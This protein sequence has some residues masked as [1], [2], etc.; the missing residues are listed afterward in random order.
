[1]TALLLHDTGRGGKLGWMVEDI[2][3]GRASGAILSAVVTPKPA[4]ISRRP[5]V[6]DALLQLNAIGADVLL[7]PATHLVWE[8]GAEAPEWYEQWDWWDPTYSDLTTDEGRQA[9]IE[10]VFDTQR[11]LGLRPLAPTVRIDGLTGPRKDI[12]L[13]MAQLAI[14]LEPDAI[15][16]LAGDIGFWGQGGRLDEF[17]GE[18]AQLRAGG[19]HVIAYTPSNRYGPEATAV[20][21][22][23]RTVHSLSL[24]SEVTVAHGDL[25]LLPAVVAG[26]VA[27]GTCYDQGQRALAHDVLCPSPSGGQHV[28]RVTFEGLLAVLGAD[29]YNGAMR[30]NSTLASSLL[31]GAA[32]PAGLLDQCRHHFKSLG[33]VIGAL[34][35]AG[36][37]RLAKASELQRRYG[38]ARTL[39]QQLDGDVPDAAQARSRFVDSPAA[40]LQ[41]YGASEGWW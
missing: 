26:A 38:R 17:V 2:Q 34:D 6:E 8:D 36:G 20:A 19:W 10:R 7:D 41:D 23:C 9:H 5:G 39:L 25:G 22:V 32:M 14:R 18:L 37:S 35:A 30:Y 11:G 29:G 27:V 40:G 31:V 24:R 3:Q 4:G 12:A 13:R 1:M 33:S 15:L 28:D 16:T 21:G